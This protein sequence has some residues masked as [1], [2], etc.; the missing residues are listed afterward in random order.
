[1]DTHIL[2]GEAMDTHNLPDL[3]APC[4]VGLRVER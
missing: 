1:M 3:V 4:S 2:P